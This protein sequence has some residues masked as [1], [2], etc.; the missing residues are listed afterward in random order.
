MTPNQRGCELL[1]ML[2]QTECGAGMMTRTLLSK[3]EVTWHI[4]SCTFSFH[5]PCEGVYLGVKHENTSSLAWRKGGEVESDRPLS[6]QPA[7]FSRCSTT[8][9]HCDCVNCSN[10]VCEKGK[11]RFWCSDE[12]VNLTAGFPHYSSH[13]PVSWTQYSNTF[14]VQ[15]ENHRTQ[16]KGQN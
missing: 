9:C 8:N 1:K 12:D 2:L 15:K 4:T 5:H 14:R 3:T 13:S 11:L 16:T 6:H 10:S 7:L